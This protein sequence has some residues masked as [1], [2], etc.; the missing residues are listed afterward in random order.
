MKKA[1]L[2]ISILISAGAGLSGCLFDTMVTCATSADCDYPREHCV[3]SECR[4]NPNYTPSGP[5]TPITPQRE[6]YPQLTFTPTYGNY[7]NFMT[8]QNWRTLIPEVSGTSGTGVGEIVI[9]LCDVDDPTCKSPKHVR[10]VTE[11]EGWKSK[12]IQGMYG[13]EISL[14]DLPAGTWNLMI[15]EDS[16]ISAANGLDWK[17]KNPLCKDGEDWNCIVSES[18]RML[19]SKEDYDT[20]Q[21]ANKDK[22][23]SYVQPSTIKVTIKDNCTSSSCTTDLGT[24][25]LGHYHERNI[26][27]DPRP[28]NGYIA[29]GTAGGLRIIDLNDFTVMN[30]YGPEYYD[31][32]LLNDDG[33]NIDGVPCG[34]IDGGDGSTVWVIYNLTK[35]D[36][37]NIAV[38]FDVQ[39][40]QQIGSKHVVLQSRISNPALCRG[41]VKDGKMV[42]WASYQGKPGNGQVVYA[43][44]IDDVLYDE[45][46]V[47][48]SD[49]NMTDSDDECSVQP[50][51]Y[52]NDTDS[53]VIWH[54]MILSIQGNYNVDGRP[55]QSNGGMCAGSE[56]LCVF[57]TRT[58]ENGLEAISKADDASTFLEG[59][60]YAEQPTTANGKIECT[61]SD[62][63]MNVPALAL[64]EKSPTEAFLI[65]SKCI[66]LAAWKLT[67]TPDSTIVAER[68]PMG[69]LPGQQNLDVSQYGVYIHDWALSPDG[70]RLY[71][72][73]SGPS[74]MMLYT[75]HGD[76]DH[77]SSSNRTLGIVLD[78][79]GDAPVV[80][81]DPQFNRNI[82]SFEGNNGDKN[83][84]SPAIDQGI[85]IQ[86]HWYTQYFSAWTN[87][88]QGQVTTFR[89]ARPMIAVSQNSLWLSRIGDGYTSG[90]HDS[91]STLGHYRDIAVYD[92]K[93]ARSILWP[94]LSETY[95]HPYTG[96]T[97]NDR[98]SG[99][100]LD[101]VNFDTINTM[102]IVYI[103]A[104]N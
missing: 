89:P 56:D 87:A 67:Y 93:E 98:P 90:G 36:A 65:A 92:L 63:F 46:N 100:P 88:I 103:P 57:M 54:D 28:E 77:W 33:T 84:K 7:L 29:V 37:Y 83:P 71:G 79:S 48:A 21:K 18:D 45:A 1:L 10:A 94:H 22:W 43:P 6:D 5:S 26:S 69:A 70:K 78:V 95:Y 66:T 73:P 13:P 102:G 85:D 53:A 32:M 64:V 12:P 86:Q 3:A 20:F 19:V 9:M 59:G 23:G 58:G 15:F 35:K 31:F 52:L 91:K 41:T 42:V 68:I 97:A 4:A 17:H 16:L 30:S 14:Y 39:T 40:K 101:P 82:D 8:I 44:S 25:T 60:A 2:L 24:L 99:F 62:Y 50:I 11:E 96:A 38:P 75:K 61:V 51:P 72:M 34:L 76:Q 55:K 81:D 27:I 104:K 74:A 47:T 49:C 80:A